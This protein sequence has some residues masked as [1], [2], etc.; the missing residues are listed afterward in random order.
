[1]PNGMYGGVRGWGLAAPAYSIGFP[2]LLDMRE[3]LML[4]YFD[5]F[6]HRKWII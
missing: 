5:L 2:G 6:I 4:G 1:M 3:L